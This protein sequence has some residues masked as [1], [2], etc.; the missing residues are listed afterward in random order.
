MVP[1][2]RILNVSDIYTDDFAFDVD[3]DAETR[4][5]PVFCY[6]QDFF[7]TR[8]LR[9]LAQEPFLMWLRW[10][11]R[12]RTEGLEN[13]PRKG[14]MLLAANHRSHADTALLLS[15]LPYGVRLRFA[16][17]AAKDFWFKR[18]FKSTLVRFYFNALA[19]TRRG[20]GARSMVSELVRYISRGRGRALLIYPE[21]GRTTAD[22]AVGEF[23]SG[24]ARIS[25]IANA[26]IVPIAVMNS[27]KLLPKGGPLRRPPADAP[28]TVVFGKPIDPADYMDDLRR[29]EVR[30]ARNMT[31]ALRDR[32]AAMIARPAEAAKIGVAPRSPE[33]PKP[34]AAPIDLDAGDP[35]AP[36]APLPPAESAETPAPEIKQPA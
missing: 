8:L 11:G 5:V 15:G 23:K 32:L 35:L 3:V 28:C 20:Q 9:G 2:P 30:A 34:D 13:L 1:N 7:T 12:V 21:G 25:L 22:G 33:L 4:H 29:N 14:P 18:R 19:V 36:S 17:A 6:W 24:V 10:Y 31:A 27:E 16:A 26:P